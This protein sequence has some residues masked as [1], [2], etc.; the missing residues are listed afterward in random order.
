MK[1]KYTKKQILESIKYWK[2]Q[3]NE[4]IDYRNY[5]KPVT[6]DNEI[7]LHVYDIEWLDVGTTSDIAPREIDIVVNANKNITKQIADKFELTDGI[8]P[9]SFKFSTIDAV[10][11]NDYNGIKATEYEEDI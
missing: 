11:C 3:L 6:Y 10:K 5:N 1:T 8:L 2:K 7:K 9:L 4:G